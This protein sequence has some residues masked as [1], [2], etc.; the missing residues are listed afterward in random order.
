M[1]EFVD[2][3]L[4][5]EEA[6]AL[7]QYLDTV[8]HLAIQLQEEKIPVKYYDDSEVGRR[9]TPCRYYTRPP[10]DTNPNVAFFKV[11]DEAGY[12]LPFK[13]WGSYHPAYIRP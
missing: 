10:N 6:T 2:E 12:S 4:T 1:R 7:G 8:H 3:H 9:T 5:E 13:V 11:S